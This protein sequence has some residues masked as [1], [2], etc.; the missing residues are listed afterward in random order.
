MGELNVMD[1]YRKIKEI[2]ESQKIYKQKSTEGSLEYI[3]WFYDLKRMCIEH[4][5]GIE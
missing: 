2:K 1:V 4:E 3:E 5:H